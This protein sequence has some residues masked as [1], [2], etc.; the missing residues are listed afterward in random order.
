MTNIEF[1][2]TDNILCFSCTGHADFA[3]KGRDIV[4]AGISALC[5]ALLQRIKE[6]QKEKQTQITDCFISDGCLILRFTQTEK[7]EE[8]LNTLMCGFRAIAHTYPENCNIVRL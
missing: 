4:C 5:M 2:Q 1:T 8:C 6:L 7:S 3:E